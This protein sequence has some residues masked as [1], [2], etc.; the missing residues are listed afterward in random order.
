MIEA[1][2]H[3]PKSAPPLLSCEWGLIWAYGQQPSEYKHHLLLGM[4]TT[5]SSPMNLDLKRCV[6]L[7]LYLF[8]LKSA[9]DFHYFLF[10]QTGTQIMIQLQAC[11]QVKY[12]R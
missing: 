8:F 7:P 9:L 3:P 6:Q 11:R 5:T 1:P 2:G 4:A 10:L 12:L